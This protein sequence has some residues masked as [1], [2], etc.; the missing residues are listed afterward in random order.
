MSQSLI[1]LVSLALFAS[2]G[3]KQAS[4]DISLEQSW[5][6][7]PH[8]H[9]QYRERALVFIKVMGAQMIRFADAEIGDLDANHGQYSP[10]A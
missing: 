1:E 9:T 4:R 8:L 10:T 7:S 2:D 6:M 5:D 3:M